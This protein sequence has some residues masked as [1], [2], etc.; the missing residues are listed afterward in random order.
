MTADLE[1]TV[2][3]LISAPQR[4]VYEAW[5]DPEMMA[6]FMAG[7]SDQVVTEAR[8]DARIGGSF[9][10]LMRSDKDIA[11]DGIYKVLEPFSRIVFTWHSPYS[12]A[13]SEVELRF[14]P[15]GSSTEVTL[16][17][18]RFLSEGARNGHRDG[19]GRILDRLNAVLATSGQ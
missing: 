3:R 12:P 14:A 2:T 13:D 17:Q 18:K 16:H 15:V 11:H 8:S 1:L 4:K 9:F 19:W 5:L 10:V 7:G 6:R